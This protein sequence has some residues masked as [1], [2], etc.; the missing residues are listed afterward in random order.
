MELF[1]TPISSPILIALTV[2]YAIAAAI[3]TFDT[4]MIQFKKAGFLSPEHPML[5]NWTGLFG[6][7][8]WGTWIAILLLNWKYAFA[9]FII[10]F[11]LK[12]LPVLETVGGILISP[13]VPKEIS[14]SLHR[15]GAKK[16]H[17]AKTLKTISR[18]KSPD[19]AKEA[20][21]KFR[22]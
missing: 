5:S 19:E 20:L 10:K 18:S 15:V 12:L 8:L 7:L 1:N 2:V 22:E 16:R 14:N 21:R 4:R 11:I 6:F 9:L 3:T 17:A 13:F